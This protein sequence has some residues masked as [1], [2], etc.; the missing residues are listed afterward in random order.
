[1][2][3]NWDNVVL[4]SSINTSIE[5]YEKLCNLDVQDMQKSHDDIITS[6][7]TRKDK[8]QK[9]GMKQGCCGSITKRIFQTIKQG[10]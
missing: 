4:V 8:T 6:D 10:D 9:D 1:M 2:Q 3:L 5:D 7:N